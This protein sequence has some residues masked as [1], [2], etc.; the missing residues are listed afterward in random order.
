MLVL[1]AYLKRISRF[2]KIDQTPDSQIKTVPEIKDL[3]RVLQVQAEDV[4]MPVVDAGMVL[5]CMGL[6]LAAKPG[7][8]RADFFSAF[9]V[10][11]V[12]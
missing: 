9:V 3:Q 5:D 1:S 10:A 7:V 2:C 6:V 4:A 12:Q 8:Q 11:G